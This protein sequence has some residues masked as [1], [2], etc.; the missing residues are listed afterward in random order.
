MEFQSLFSW[1][2]TVFEKYGYPCYYRISI[3]VFLDFNNSHEKWSVWRELQFQSLFSWILTSHRCNYRPKEKAFQ[4]LFSW[5]LTKISPF[6]LG[7][8]SEIFQSLFSWILTCLWRSLTMSMVLWEI[9]ILVFLDFNSPLFPLL[10]S[11]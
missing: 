10:F 6:H 5:I 4:S 2:L 9:S 3:L 11:L 7:I 1:I 8:P